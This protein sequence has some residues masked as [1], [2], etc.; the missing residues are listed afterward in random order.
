VTNL[1]KKMG[2]RQKKEVFYNDRARKG[3]RGGR[4]TP[5]D[6]GARKFI[7]GREGS[8]FLANRDWGGGTNGIPGGRQKQAGKKLGKRGAGPCLP[9]KSSFSPSP[10]VKRS[11][12]GESTPYRR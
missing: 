9:G 10:P 11:E 1:E 6:R 8:P 3:G 4:A 2:T 5:V 12:R 7:K